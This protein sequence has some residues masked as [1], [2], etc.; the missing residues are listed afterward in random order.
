MSDR[1]AMPDD[2]T[3]VLAALRHGI[4]R[5]LLLAQT[6]A[7]NPL[8]ASEARSLTGRLQSIQAEVDAIA[9]SRERPLP[10]NSLGWHLPISIWE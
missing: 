2:R 3:E 5:S 7:G 4:E 6:L 8:I 9:C 1:N 10:D